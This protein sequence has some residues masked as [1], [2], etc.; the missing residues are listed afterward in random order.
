MIDAGAMAWGICA[1]ALDICSRLKAVV[2][3]TPDGLVLDRRD[4]TGGQHVVGPGQHVD[5]G[6]PFGVPASLVCVCGSRHEDDR[7]GPDLHAAG[8]GQ[9]EEQRQCRI[10][11]R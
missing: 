5:Q 10:G 11:A 1:S 9:Q 3:L 4:R 2:C 7:H 8:S 6:F